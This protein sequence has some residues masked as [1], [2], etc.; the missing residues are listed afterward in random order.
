M[1]VSSG[2]GLTARSLWRGRTLGREAWGAG[3]RRVVLG[4]ILPWV[5]FDAGRA[6]EARATRVV[7]SLF[8]FG[9]GEDFVGG[10]DP[11]EPLA[12]LDLAARVSVGVV[13]EGCKTHESTVRWE[14]QQ[15]ARSGQPVGRTYQVFCTAS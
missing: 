15:E 9:I 11:G 14:T 3:R 1:R 8:L 10:L 7:V 12:G 5:A 13:F 2:A 4:D 6:G